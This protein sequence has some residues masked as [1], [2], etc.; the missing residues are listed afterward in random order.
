MPLLNLNRTHAPSEGDG[1]TIYDNNSIRAEHIY[2]QRRHWSDS[3]RLAP[4]IG[5]DYP[6]NVAKQ[7]ML[8]HD[9][10]AISIAG[11]LDSVEWT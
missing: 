7:E 3:P 10:L 5:G 6:G 11:C 9:I 4:I 1:R 2:R 8:R